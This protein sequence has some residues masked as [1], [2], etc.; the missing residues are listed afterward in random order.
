[1]TPI[2]TKFN[3]STPLFLKEQLGLMK[4]RKIPD[5][6]GEV[7]WAV[8]EHMED[9]NISLKEVIEAIDKQGEGIVKMKA[10]KDYLLKITQ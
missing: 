5:S 8:V 9:E 3:M 2:Y 4:K 7:I 10:L 1:M 6:L